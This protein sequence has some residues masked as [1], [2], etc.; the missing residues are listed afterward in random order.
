MIAGQALDNCDQLSEHFRDVRN[1]PL[2]LRLYFGL[3]GPSMCSTP[4]G[5]G[6]PVAKFTAAAHPSRHWAGPSC[7]AASA[8]H[9]AT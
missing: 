9:A 6:R 7:Y 3:Y 2:A 5:Y 1:A 4:R 8:F